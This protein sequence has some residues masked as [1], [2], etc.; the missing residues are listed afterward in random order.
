MAKVIERLQ[1]QMK[2]PPLV[3]IKTPGNR[4]LGTNLDPLKIAAVLDDRYNVQEH[5]ATIR[6]VAPI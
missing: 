3:L 2:F 4:H 1:R 5:L 6:M